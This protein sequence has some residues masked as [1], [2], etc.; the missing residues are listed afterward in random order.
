MCHHLHIDKSKTI[1]SYLLNDSLAHMKKKWILMR[2]IK[3]KYTTKNLYNRMYDTTY[4]LVKQ[5]CIQMRTFIDIFT[6]TKDPL[7]FQY[8]INYIENEAKIQN[9]NTIS[10]LGEPKYNINCTPYNGDWGRPQNDGPALR[11]IIMF[12]IIELFHK[13]EIVIQQL[14]V[15]IILKDLDYILQ[16]YK[17]T[18]FDLWEEC[19]GWHFYTRMV[20]TKFLNETIKFKKILKLGCFFSILH[21]TNAGLSETEAKLLTVI[22]RGLLFWSVVVTTAI[23]VENIPRDFFK[24]ASSSISFN[25]NFSLELFIKFLKIKFIIFI[26]IILCIISNYL[27]I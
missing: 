5:G 19:D 27:F 15:P 20:Q 26:N 3:K 8:I 12:Q 21:N 2:D 14:I 23:P 1:N 10:G 16:N 17:K 7:Y 24:R 25:T 4:S 13:Y 18:S 6:K 11:G 22:P 9:L